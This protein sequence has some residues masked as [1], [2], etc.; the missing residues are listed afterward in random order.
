MVKPRQKATGKPTYRV[1]SDFR[2]LNQ[3]IKRV[4]LQAP[5]V[6]NVLDSISC[7]S[8][9]V[10]SVLDLRHGFFQRSLDERDRH[11]TAFANDSVQLW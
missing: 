2:Y 9:N 1:V 5:L 10:F 3:N 6:A 8:T 11:L 7:G 4:T